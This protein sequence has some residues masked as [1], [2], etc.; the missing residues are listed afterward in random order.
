MPDYLIAYD[1]SAPKRLKKSTNASAKK[2]SR[3]KTA[4]SSTAPAPANSSTSGKNS[5]K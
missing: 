2:P 5:R 3:Y 1:I 4:P